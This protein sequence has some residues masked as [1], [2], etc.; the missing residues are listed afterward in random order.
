MNWSNQ[1]YIVAINLKT[2]VYYTGAV[3]IYLLLLGS[4]RLL[5][6]VVDI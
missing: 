6:N 5:S 4:N 1:H 3:K 2:L